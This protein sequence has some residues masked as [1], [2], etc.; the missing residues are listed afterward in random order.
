MNIFLLSPGRT[1]TTTFSEAFK[2]I[3][4]YTSAHQSRNPYLGPARID[5]PENHFECDNR[6]TWFLPRL[7]N[8]Y[9][10][11]GVLVKVTRD[12][13]S[14]AR[15]YHKR[16]PGIRIMKAYSQGILRRPLKDNSIEVCKDYVN[17]VYEQIDFH[18][19]FWSNFIE[20][21]LHKPE[22]GMEQLFALLGV[23]GTNALDYLA[24]H[25]LNESET[26]LRPKI[27]HLRANIKTLLYDLWV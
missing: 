10:K 18:A 3:D 26:G 14:I 2:K 22:P 19:P 4:G 8:K 15:S 27:N 24:R 17:N 21:D 11:S 23:D 6:L 1:A 7:T 13:D 20:I 25:R 12:R 9:G 16:W 5:Y